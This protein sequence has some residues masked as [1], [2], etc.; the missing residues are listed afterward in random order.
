MQADDTVTRYLC[1]TSVW[2][3]PYLNI[4]GMDYIMS[5][6]TLNI[7]QEFTKNRRPDSSCDSSN[8]GVRLNTNYS[9]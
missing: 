9:F 1:T 3:V 8:L 2:V 4:D 5:S 7:A 6:D